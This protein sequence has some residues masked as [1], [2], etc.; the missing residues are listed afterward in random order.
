M[1]YKG[2]YLFSLAG[3][4]LLLI[5]S[6]GSGLWHEPRNEYNELYFI[7][8]TVCHQLPDRS[9]FVNGVQMAVNTRCFGIF[10]GLFF[11]WLFI[12]IAGSKLHGKK[13]PIWLISLAV[14]IQVVDYTGNF[15][16]MW[17]NTNMSRFILGS[18]LGTAVAIFLSNSF[19]SNQNRIRRNEP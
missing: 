5:F 19:Y 18:T 3:L 8:S 6:M 14:I 17:V 4:F 16:Q 9:F 15:F 11:G 13:W 12:P 1:L 2:L 7:F 10:A